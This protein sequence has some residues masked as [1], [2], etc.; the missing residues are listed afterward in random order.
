MTRAVSRWLA[1][2]AALLTLLSVSGVYAADRAF[3]R[4]FPASGQPALNTTGNISLI[5][6]TSETCLVAASPVAPATCAASVLS[7]A[8]TTTGSL[9]TSN[10]NNYNMVYVNQGGAAGNG[11]LNASQSV[12]GIPASATVKWAGLYWA[13]ETATAS[14][15]TV[16]FATP[17]AGYRLVT[18]SVVDTSTT[19]AN[20]Y[21]GFA[22]VSA[23]VLSGGNGTYT[24]ADVQSTTGAVDKYAGWSLVVVYTD[25]SEKPRNLAVFDGLV[26][27]ANGSPKKIG[28]AHV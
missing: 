2:L 24:V 14:R 25:A 22:D 15:N 6:N 10:N 8:A 11:T 13:G 21:Q 16:R 7:V 23:D 1:L 27:V 26:S 17:K 5:G 28:R 9:A 19:N 18:A 12:L 4:R 3:A 20:R